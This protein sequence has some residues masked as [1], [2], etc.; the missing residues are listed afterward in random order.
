MLAAGIVFV[1]TALTYAEMSSTF[2]EPG[3]SATFTRYAFNDLISFIAGW[4]LLLDYIVTIAISAF[5][6]PPYLHHVLRI[7][8]IKPIDTV[9]FHCTFSVCIIVFLFFLNFFGVKGSGRFSLMLAIFTILT[10]AGII[11]MGA[12]LFLNLP[13]IISHM[14]IGVPGVDWSPDWWGFAKGCAMAMV[15]YTGIEA[16]SQLAAETKQPAQSIPRAIK[17][18]AAVV[19]FLYVGLSTVGLSVLSPVQLGTT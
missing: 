7:M 12:L 8:G 15:A 19:I 18:T 16:I 3:G 17:W 13:L 11:L 9:W 10:Q 5:A 4:G 14:R 1:C 2:P 6:V